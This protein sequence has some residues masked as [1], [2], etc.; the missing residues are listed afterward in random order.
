MTTLWKHQQEGF[1][2][3]Y[4]KPATMLAGGMG[5]GKSATAVHLMSKWDCRRTLIICP[6]SVRGVWRRELPKHCPTNIRPIVLDDGSV[7]DRT[8]NAAQA[9]RDPSPAAVIINLESSWREPFASWALSQRWDLAMYDEAHGI[10]NEGTACSHFACQLTKH[11]HRRL[12]LTGTPLAHSPLDAWGQYRFLDPKIFGT[13]YQA[14]LERY[15]APQQMRLRKRLTSS[16]AKLVEALAKLFGDDSPQVAQWK[17]P[18]NVNHLVPGLKNPEEFAAKIAPVT[19]RCKSADVLDLPPL[20]TSERF[21]RLD[22]DG[23]NA[24]N[25]LMLNLTCELHR[26]G[27]DINS[28]FTLLTRLQQV[29][30]GFLPDRDGNVHRVDAAKADALYDLLAE[31]NEPT[32]VFCRYTHDLDVVQ[33]V[34]ALLGRRYGELSGRRKD[35]INDMATMRHDLD[36]IGVMPQSGGVGIDLSYAKIG[37]WYSLARYLCHYDQ[38]VTRLHR[39]GTTGTRMYSLIV[40]GTIDEEIH[41]CIADRREITE[42]VLSRLKTRGYAECPP[43]KG[44]VCHATS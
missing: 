18:S 22:Q 26:S 7:A 23:R 5:V 33:E 44:T 15:A 12:A 31:T 16:Q 42:G 40:Q 4:T 24:Y 36:V 1:D 39:P 3:A 13:D 10:K 27:C 14:Y 21:I 41:Q 8:A 9:L 6:P 37:V 28:Y 38:G 17:Q 43:P 20:I 25:S 35:A 29:T 2:F 34:V 32:V 19:W 30:S 11:S